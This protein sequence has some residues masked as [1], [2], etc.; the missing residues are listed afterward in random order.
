MRSMGEGVQATTARRVF[1]R[2]GFPLRLRPSY[3]FAERFF[4]AK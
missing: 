3:A 2:D 4:H 1:A